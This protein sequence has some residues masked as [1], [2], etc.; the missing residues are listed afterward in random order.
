[1]LVDGTRLE[2]SAST[3]TTRELEMGPEKSKR[4]SR[5]RDQLALQRRGP[6]YWPTVSILYRAALLFPERI[7]GTRETWVMGKGLLQRQSACP[8]QL[9]LLRPYSHPRA[10]P[11]PGHPSPHPQVP[12]LRILPSADPNPTRFSR[13]KSAAPPRGNVPYILPHRAHS[14]DN[15]Y[16]LN[17]T[18]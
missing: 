18:V 15:I 12:L 1:M 17:H 16:S 5:D 9:T 2:E 14:S 10:L 13:P 7:K 11:W 3:K 6:E 8:G 4:A